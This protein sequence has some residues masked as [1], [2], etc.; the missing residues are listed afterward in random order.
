MLRPQGEAGGLRAGLLLLVVLGVVGVALAL[1]YDRHWQ[2]P[3]QLAPWI[4]LGVISVSWIALVLRRSEA[5]VWLARAVAILVIVIAVLG[6]WQH[7][8]AN[9]DPGPAGDEHADPAT[10][11]VDSSGADASGGHHDDDEETTAT[12]SDGDHPGREAAVEIDATDASGAEPTSGDVS[13]VDAM[14]GSAGHAPVPAALA[15]V[16]VGLALALATI[17][18]GGSRRSS[19]G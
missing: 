5:T 6:V 9:Y 19:Q 7:T 16:P 12:S 15:I 4:T 11:R 10:T 13:L 2:S 18:L 8:D 17:G 3:W 1:A 14:T